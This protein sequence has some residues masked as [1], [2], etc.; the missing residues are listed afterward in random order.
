MKA[1]TNV[2]D[3]DVLVVGGGIAGCLAALTARDQLGDTARVVIVDKARIGRSGQSPFAA[4][5][6]TVF[7]PDE[8]D[9]DEWLEEIV[10]S[11]EYLNDQLWCRQMFEH[12]RRV[13]QQLDDW[14]IGYRSLVFVKDENGKRMRRKSRGHNK[15]KHDVIYSLPM[16]DALRRR[17]RLQHVTMVE[18]VMVTDLVTDDAGTVGGAIGFNYWANETYLFRARA[19]IVAASGCGFKSVYFGH[20]NL[21]GDLQA[22]AFDAGAA[23][24]NMEQFYSNTVARDFDIH[25]MNLYVSVGG[26]FV[27]GLGEEF[28]W[29]YHPTLGNRANLQNLNLAFSREVLEGR[30]PVYMDITGAKPE[31]EELC[32]RILPETFR[33]WD[34]AGISPFRE[35]VQWMPAFK[36]TTAGGGGIKTDLRCRTTVPGLYA[37]GDIC[38]IAVHGTYSFGGINIAWAAI[39]GDLAGRFAG[40]DLQSASVGS[41][42]IPES[43]VR[44]LVARRL[45]PVR[46]TKGIGPDEVIDRIQ[47]AIIP[48]EVAYLK[49]LPALEQAEQRLGEIEAELAPQLWASDAHELVKA[50]EARSMLVVA[51]M[52]LAAS[53]LREESRGFHFRQEFPRTNNRDWLKLILLRRDEAD[54]AAELLPVETPFIQPAEEFSL[55]PGVKRAP[56][57]ASV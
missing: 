51:R 3:C 50:N 6:F 30:G 44:K 54:L 47:E 34:R 56:T 36:G 55:P 22:A 38:W 13:A 17:L 41:P 31:D 23:F 8:D 19:T 15:T 1:V 29:D 46:R 42:E 20:R 35:K 40:E 45:E 10:V 32:R 18:R 14:A 48:F 37:A 49:T 12:S 28:M 11:G 5:V 24:T 26:K 25:G 21:T 16:M 52:M 27:N 43:Q 2:I 33:L 53:K 9:L 57:T 4:G 7:D 39:S